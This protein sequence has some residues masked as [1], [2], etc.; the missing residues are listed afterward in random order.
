MH[1]DTHT[2]THTYTSCHDGD[3]AGQRDLRRGGKY[4]WGANHTEGGLGPRPQGAPP[5]GPP[6]PGQTGGPAPR[7]KAHYP[8]GPKPSMGQ[9]PKQQ[10]RDNSQSG[11]PP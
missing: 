6:Q 9:H 8:P 3:M 5:Q 4:L 11:R 1:K 2:H 10:T 7:F